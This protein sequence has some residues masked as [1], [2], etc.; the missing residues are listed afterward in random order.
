MGEQSQKQTLIMVYTGNGK[1]KTSA[2]VGQAVRAKGS[3]L[4]VAF[5][6]FLKR[7]HQAGEQIILK[8][9][10]GH[11]FFASGLGF[12]RN[13]SQYSKHRNA[14]KEMINWADNKISNNYDLL[15]LD[16]A[17]YA[18]GMELLKKDE[19]QELMDRAMACGIN[20][21]LTGRNA[22][23]WLT[24]RADMVS[25]LLEVKHHF[26]KNISASKGIEF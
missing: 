10:L 3:G 17:I 25:E 21:V 22:P 13:K 8:S 6:Q 1:G 24:E 2:A 16:E 7:D 20:L 15:I 18:L 14:V 19:L 26:Q 4:N 23:A 12:Y 5:G 11:D 9:L